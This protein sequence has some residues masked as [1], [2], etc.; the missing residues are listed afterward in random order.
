MFKY[1]YAFKTIF[2]LQLMAVF[3]LQKKKKISS[4]RMLEIGKN[5]LFFTNKAFKN[6]FLC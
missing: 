1:S 2:K 5:F 6:F 4:Q 3:I